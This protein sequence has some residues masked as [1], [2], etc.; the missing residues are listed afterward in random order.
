VTGVT[1]EARERLLAA[2]AAWDATPGASGSA[3]EMVDACNAVAA[4]LGIS[5]VVFRDALSRARRDG[6]DRTEAL[7]RT[8]RDH[9]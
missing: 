5:A 1:P 7:D 4:Q 8:V 9:S 3:I 2:W 6:L